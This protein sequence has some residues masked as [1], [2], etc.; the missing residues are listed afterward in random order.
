M[1]SNKKHLSGYK[2]RWRKADIDTVV[3]HHVNDVSSTI[4][5]AEALSFIEESFQ[6]IAQ[7]EYIQ[8]QASQCEDGTAVHRDSAVLLRQMETD[9]TCGLLVRKQCSTG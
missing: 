6:V 8:M 3:T 9:P 2:K 4:E 1:S 7:D 5:H